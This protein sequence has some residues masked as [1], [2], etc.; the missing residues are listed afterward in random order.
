MG[1]WIGTMGIKGGVQWWYKKEPVFWLPAGTFPYW[2]EWIVAFPRAPKGSILGGKLSDCREREY[3]GV[4]DVRQPCNR[5]CGGARE[6][7]RCR[8]EGS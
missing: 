6:G 3:D 4:W 5:V 1:V 2:V 8:K 7:Y